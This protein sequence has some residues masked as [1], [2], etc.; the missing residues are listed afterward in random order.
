MDAALR[1]LLTCLAASFL[2]AIGCSAQPVPQGRTAGQPPAAAARETAPPPEQTGGFDGRK[3]YAQLERIVGFGPRPPG[4]E[5]IHRE[6]EYIRAQLE[7]FGCSV[8]TDDFHAATPMGVVAME[9]I[10]AKASGQGAGIILLLTHYD[11]LRLPGF[12]GADDGGSSTALMLE[13]ARL[14]CAPASRRK[15]SLPVWIAFLDG[16]EAFAHWSD[17]DG[18]YGSRELAARLA[19]SGE[20]K[21]VRAVI[22]ADMIGDRDLGIRRESNSTPWLTDLVWKTAK[23]LG[24]GKYFPDASTAIEDDHIPFLRRGVPAVDL[25][26]LDYAYWHTPEDTL[27]KVSR[28]S[29]AVVGHV[30]LETLKELAKRF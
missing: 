9:N 4:S 26:D 24:Y 14:V 12:V 10:L 22:L 5:A 27:D 18:T 13:M 7:T 17:T 3:A 25:I 15:N 30:I 16:E 11:T 29:I 6:Q 21:H 2:P 20:L 19:L 23:R 28:K 8:E 1:C